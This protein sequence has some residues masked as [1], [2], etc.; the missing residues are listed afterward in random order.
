[1]QCATA[2]DA[3]LAWQDVSTNSI[4]SN[5][6]NNVIVPAAPSMQFFRLFRP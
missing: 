5:A 3:P 4:L 6:M 2:L 1:L